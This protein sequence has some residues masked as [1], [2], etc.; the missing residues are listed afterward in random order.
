[1]IFIF[2]QQLFWLYSYVTFGTKK[3]FIIFIAYYY[4]FVLF[5]FIPE[6]PRFLIIK[7]R[8]EEAFEVF[9]KIAKYNGKINPNLKSKYDLTED[10][11]EKSVNSAPN[12]VNT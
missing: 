8:K 12:E 1:M 10:E 4:S 5:R 2:I 6:S 11:F 7:N 9:Q 3:K